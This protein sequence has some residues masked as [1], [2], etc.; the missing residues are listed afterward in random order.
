V[1]FVPNL[2]YFWGP[3]GLYAE[4][5][6]STVG[7]SGT[8]ST[9][10]AVVKKTN[11]VD[12]KGKTIGTVSTT[13][14]STTIQESSTNLTNFGWQIAAS[15]MLTGED[16]AFRAISPRRKFSPSTGGWGG[17][18]THGPCRAVDCRFQRLPDLCGP[19]YSG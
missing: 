19:E 5:A 12:S 6:W 7:V 11:V 4:A 10:K 17:S 18:S 8:Q 15:Y 14:N 3:F 13:S 1:R 16:N 2:Q 9:T